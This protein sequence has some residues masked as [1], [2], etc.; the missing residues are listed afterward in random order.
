MCDLHNVTSSFNLFSC[1]LVDLEAKLANS[2]IYSALAR[3]IV[4]LQIYQRQ[5]FEISGCDEAVKPSR[6]GE[7]GAGSK[8]HG[9]IGAG[10]VLVFFPQIGGPWAVDG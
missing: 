8:K 4:S 3:P 7:R 5:P 1:L 10:T 9:E 2:P 6:G